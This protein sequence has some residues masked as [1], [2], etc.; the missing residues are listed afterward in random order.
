MAFYMRITIHSK[1][2]KAT[3]K[4]VISNRIHLLPLF[5]GIKTQISF[6]VCFL[7]PE[8]KSHS[9]RGE[10]EQRGEGHTAGRMAFQHQSRQNSLQFSP[11]RVPHIRVD[12]NSNYNGLSD[13]K[14][15]RWQANRVSQAVKVSNTITFF[16]CTISKKILGVRKEKASQ[17]YS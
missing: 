16:L 7:I 5:S 11:T 1:R 3:N 6:A 9:R 10:R 2:F 13:H 8:T 12:K 4:P 14:E 17:L 15:Q